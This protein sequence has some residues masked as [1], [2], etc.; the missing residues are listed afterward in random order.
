[1]PA[2]AESTG[3]RSRRQSGHWPARVSRP[4]PKLVT[5]TADSHGQIPA[6]CERDPVTAP[7]PGVIGAAV[8]KAARQSAGLSLRNLAR[9][10]GTSSALVRAW[11]DG[12]CPLYA[13]RYD[14]LSQVAGILRRAGARVGQDVGELVVAGQCDLL[15]TGMLLGFED[16]VEV[17]PVDHGNGG[18]T[19]RSLL[20]W[21]LNGEIPERYRP[22]ASA[23]PLLAAR[24]IAS[25]IAI[26]QNLQKGMHGTDLVSY[27][28]AL[29]ALA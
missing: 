1:M 6:S 12:S 3:R 28:T 14:Q 24:N 25:F 23:G 18:T 8:I 16:Y 9:Q 29:L 19:A 22:F 7:P 2:H 27:G 11:E 5:T 26:A 4:D 21:A 13:V 20:R 10:I 17:P 15:I